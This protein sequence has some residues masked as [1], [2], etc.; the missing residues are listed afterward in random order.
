M[1]T[2]LENY[3]GYR[4]QLL[5]R[6]AQPPISPADLWLYGEI[7]YRI[8][9]LETCQMFCKTAPS[10]MKTQVL[11]GHYQMLDAYVQSL[12]T[13]RRYGP[14][15]GPDTQKERDAAQNNLGRVIEDYRK[16][17]SSFKPSSPETYGH[18]ISKLIQ[19]LLP[20]WLQFR[21]TFVPIKKEKKEAPQ[22]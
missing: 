3:Y 15:R 1:A 14:N 17:F 21:N 13:E 16:R 18:A 8:G 4:Q 10:T 7:L 20:A 2:V 5:Q 11:L 6:M 9:V 12:A 19:T 22:S